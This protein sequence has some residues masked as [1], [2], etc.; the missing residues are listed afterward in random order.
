MHEMDITRQVLEIALKE[1]QKAGARNIKR[2]NLVIGELSSVVDDSVQFY[3]DFLSRDSIAQGA[4]LAFHRIPFQA[5]CK[6]CQFVFTPETDCWECPQCR[7]WDVDIVSGK[8]FY[9]DSIEVEL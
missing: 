5:R 8:E 1:A 7:Q 6:K 3:F 4:Q 9:L 2:I